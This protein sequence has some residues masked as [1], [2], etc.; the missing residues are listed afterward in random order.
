MINAVRL[1]A[2]TTTC[3]CQIHRCKYMYTTSLVYLIHV[4]VNVLIVFS[5]THWPTLLEPSFEVH[6]KYALIEAEV[7]VSASYMYMYVA[8]SCVLIGCM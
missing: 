5:F 6:L 7:H 3:R 2:L 1:V 4:H 8:M